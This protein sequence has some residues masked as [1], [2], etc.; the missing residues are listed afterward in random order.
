MLGSSILQTQFNK[1]PIGGQSLLKPQGGRRKKSLMFTL[2]LTSLIDAF[3]ILVIYLLVNFSSPTASLRVSGDLEI[4]GA[5]QSATLA[6]GTV[7]SVSRGHYF[8]NDNEITADQLPQKLISLHAS[9]RKDPTQKDDLVI[10][11][12][13]RLDYAALSPVIQA[14]SQAGFHQ[15][16]FAVLQG[17]LGQ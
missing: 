9:L 6:P 7:V 8:I 16:K 3:S 11:A 1:G 17:R 2:T 5:N 14:G 15:F 13:R 10:Q 4:P 12:D